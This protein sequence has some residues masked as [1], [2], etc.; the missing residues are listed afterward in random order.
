[1]W[2]SDKNLS[3][4]MKRLDEWLYATRDLRVREK[5]DDA[6][7]KSVSNIAKV[8]LCVEVLNLALFI[9]FNFRG[10]V[11]PHAMQSVFQVLFCII[12]CLTA[13][14]FTKML[15]SHR[16]SGDISHVKEELLVGSYYAVMSCWGML[17][18]AR[19]FAAGEQM[20]TF[21]IVQ[22]CFVCFIIM[23]PIFILIAMSIVFTT[24]FGILLVIGT[25]G[26]QPLNYIAFVVLVMISA[27]TRY[28]NAVVECEKTLEIT[29]LNQVLV[30]SAM[31]DELT[32]LKNRHALRDDF[33]NYQNRLVYIM[34]ADIDSFKKVNDVY[35]HD[36]GDIA[37]REVAGSLKR[38]FPADSIYRFGG[39][40]FL[41]I[42]P[43]YKKAEFDKSIQKWT[44]SLYGI[45]IPHTMSHINCSY[46]F[47]V[48]TPKDAE[49][50]R[51]LIKEADIGLYVMK[52]QRKRYAAGYGM[53]MQ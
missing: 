42:L 46:G 1:M 33:M 11:S 9:I 48:G 3:Y 17:V 22:M 12:A 10:A 28:R 51:G 21:Y 37:I 18:D 50:L 2:K 4:Y 19:H 30:R 49:A 24:F 13:T 20:L 43:E 41:I 15:Q 36:A 32:G 45:Q 16:L 53:P 29:D 26:M 23:R 34:M 38:T 31:F 8:I 44:R 52:D 5:L 27:I 25:G 39:D 35:G 6:N 7:I 40:E 14:I 47:T